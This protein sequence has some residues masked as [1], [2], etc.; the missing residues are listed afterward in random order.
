MPIKLFDR[1]KQKTTTAGS[2][3]VT[4]G[5]SVDSFL[6]FSSVFSNGDQTFYTIESPTI[7]EVGLGTYNAGTV[8]RDTVFKSSN[9][10]QLVNL[11]GDL[12]TSTDR[13]WET[14]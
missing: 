7:F 13:D 8:S 14:H 4:L 1:V 10:D 11:P 5:D 6:D 12:N 3:P 2:G 9:S